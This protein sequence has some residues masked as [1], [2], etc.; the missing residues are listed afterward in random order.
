MWERHLEKQS[1]Y[2]KKTNHG[3]NRRVQIQYNTKFKQ[4]R[5]LM[6]TKRR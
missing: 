5:Q 6:K 4:F 1:E 3:M 2:D